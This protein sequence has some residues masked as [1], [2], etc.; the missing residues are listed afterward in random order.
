[1]IYL[2]K[3]STIASGSG[4]DETT[5]NEENEP[6]QQFRVKMPFKMLTKSV[7]AG[8]KFG[9]EA[10]SNVHHNG[11]SFAQQPDTI[12]AIVTNNVEENKQ[13]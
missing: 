3:K 5:L 10:S 4:E 9:Q 13:D 8:T 1:M 7:V 2:K 12:N 6:K 11:E